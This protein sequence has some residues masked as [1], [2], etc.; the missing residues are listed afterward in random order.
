MNPVWAAHIDRVFPWW[1]RTALTIIVHAHELASVAV[2][3]TAKRR[4]RQT[5]DA[6]NSESVARGHQS[7]SYV[8]RIPPRY[9]DYVPVHHQ[10]VEH[11]EARHDRHLYV[12]RGARTRQMIT[13]IAWLDLGRG[14]GEENGA[15]CKG[16]RQGSYCH[17]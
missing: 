17:C 3:A 11:Y 16:I 6:L 12:T 8:R 10:T 4:I 5:I 15:Q 1:G 9:F 13:T 2:A 7:P 14:A